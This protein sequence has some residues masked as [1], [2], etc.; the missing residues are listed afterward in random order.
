MA[1]FIYAVRLFYSSN[2]KNLMIYLLTSLLSIPILFAE[3]FVTKYVVDVIQ[4]TTQNTFNFTDAL[5]LIALLNFILYAG[6]VTHSLKAI[7]TTNLRVT[8]LYEIENKILNKTSALS[9]KDIENPFVKTMR[10][11]AKR[12]S[13]TGTLDQWVGLITNLISLIGIFV[14]LMI[15]GFYYL[16]IIIAVVLLLQMRISKWVSK[17]AEDTERGQTSSIR[18]FDYIVELL[19]DRKSVQEI[20]V[21]KMYKYL[22]EKMRVI[23]LNNFKQTQKKLILSETINFS[24]DVVTALLRGISI[25]LLVVV[26]GGNG[27]TAGAF[28]MLFQV[29]NQLYVIF[30]SFIGSYSGLQASHMRFT[31]YSSYL[32]MEEEAI[33]DEA[34]VLQSKGLGIVANQLIFKYPTNQHDTLKN[35]NFTIKPG[36]S[37][38]F[39]GEN[40]SGKTT[41][42]KMILGLYRPTSGTIKWSNENGQVQI[43]N[44]ANESRVIF[45]D[46]IKLLRPV[47]E[48]VAIGNISMINNDSALVQALKKADAD[49]FSEGLDTFLGP[50]FGGLDLSGGQ[51]QRLA[52]GRAYLKESS[53][54]IFDEPTAS[55]DPN[56]EKKAFDIFVNLGDQQTSI[57]VTHRLY[58]TKFVDEIFMFENG[59]IVERGSH[60]ELMNAKGKYEKMFRQQSTLYSSKNEE[61]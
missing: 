57:I 40:G 46:F 59:E 33:P 12:F 4:G 41:L 60:K 29:V 58:I 53:L 52:I 35:I 39:V 30:P 11:K 25:L 21:Y 14:V 2:K 28:V 20:R 26:L 56:S 17:K 45:Q 18:V 19:V 16:A 27:Q 49:S 31:D 6:G 1:N 10:E 36:S 3:L 54:T 51:W 44:V 32:K 43:H 22:S 15:W 24:Q 34:S 13:L 55:L 5:Y 8:D 37:V 47:R 7:S 50:Q 48:N 23:F 42:V 38:A 61:V 9:L